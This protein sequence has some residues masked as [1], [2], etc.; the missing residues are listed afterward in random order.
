[1]VKHNYFYKGFVVM[2]PPPLCPLCNTQKMNSAN[3]TISVCTK[4]NI[5]ILVGNCQ[6]LQN[7]P[8]KTYICPPPPS[9]TVTKH[10][11][12]MH[13]AYS[14]ISVFNYTTGLNMKTANVKKLSNKNT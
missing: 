5:T 3:T 14:T 10:K 1:M 4:C 9:M 7:Y 6:S 8:I 11:K 12:I 13:S 2:D